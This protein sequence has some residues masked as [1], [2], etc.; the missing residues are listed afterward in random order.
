LRNRALS[1][2]KPSCEADGANACHATEKPS[3]GALVG[4]LDLVDYRVPEAAGV[5]RS[6][7]TVRILGG[8]FDRGRTAA[9]LTAIQRQ[10]WADL[11]AHN[12]HDCAGMRKVCLT[13]APEVA[14]RGADGQDISTAVP[15]WGHMREQLLDW[16]AVALLAGTVFLAIG[17]AALSEGHLIHATSG[18]T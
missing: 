3:T 6:A 16:L 4:Y 12:A 7:A 15:T 10:R 8:A 18:H 17:L 1:S 9:Q 5:G 11:R 14:A 2:T 13:A